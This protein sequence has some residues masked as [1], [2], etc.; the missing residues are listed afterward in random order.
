MSEDKFY[1]PNEVDFANLKFSSIRKTSGLR[2]IQAYNDKKPFRLQIPTSRIPFDLN[3][4]FYNQLELNISL[5]NNQ[6]MIDNIQA[7][8]EQMVQFAIENKWFKSKDFIYTP[9]LKKSKDDK[10]PPTIRIKFQKKD[11]DITTIFYDKKKD[12]IDIHKVKD[13]INLL[14]KDTYIKSAIECVGVWINDTKFG[15]TWKAVQLRVMP[16]P[17]QPTI[18]PDEYMFNSDSES[19]GS[20]MELMIDDDEQN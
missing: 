12:R 4:N 16:N 19:F 10:Y 3:M 1:K 5:G 9:M 20:D 8:D 2:F 11:D 7:I 15:L 14:K 17:N 18:E 13:V 6:E